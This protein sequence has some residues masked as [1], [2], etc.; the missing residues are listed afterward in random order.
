MGVNPQI[1]ANIPAAELMSLYGSVGWTG[2]TDHPAKVTS[3]LS[4]SLWWKSFHD[5]DGYADDDGVSFVRYNF[6]R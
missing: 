2:Y 3:I 5:D 6:E 4:G 1:R